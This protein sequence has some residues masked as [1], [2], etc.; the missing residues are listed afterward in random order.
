[1]MRF[2]FDELKAAQAASVLLERA[3]GSMEYIKLIKL[4]YLADSAALIET[5]SPI[6]GDRYVSMKYGPVLSSVLN[7]I[8][9]DHPRED[10]M[11]HRYVRRHNWEVE[12]ADRAESTHLS[13]YDIDLLNEIFDRYGSWRPWA[14]VN[15]TH[16]LPEWTDPGD[17][18]IPI[19]PAEILPYAG[20]DDYALGL[21]LD[22]AEAVYAMKTR[23]ARPI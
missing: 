17:T 3:G 14:V 4:L 22:Q 20:F 11:W 21:A 5:E 15:Q 10:S 18:S 12:L 2:V 7:L 9:Q 13:E 1:M 8:K 16:A 23:L 19:D 6:T